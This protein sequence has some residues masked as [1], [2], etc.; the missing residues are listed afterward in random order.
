MSGGRNLVSEELSE[1]AT[2]EIFL[3]VQQDLLHKALA[4]I[5]DLRLKGKKQTRD[6]LG[7]R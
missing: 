5:Q 4:Q 7:E 6:A 2:V 1:V 3:P